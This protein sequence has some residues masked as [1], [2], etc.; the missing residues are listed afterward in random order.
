MIREIRKKYPPRPEEPDVHDMNELMV[1]A[2]KK[3]I[4]EYE[5]LADFTVENDNGQDAGLEKLIKII[6]AELDAE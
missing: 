3:M 1:F 2:Y 5:R 4:P 6:R